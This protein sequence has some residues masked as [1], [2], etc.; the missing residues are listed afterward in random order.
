MRSSTATWPGP[1]RQG[2]ASNSHRPEHARACRSPARARRPP[3][4]LLAAARKDGD[5]PLLQDVARVLA[6]LLHAADKLHKCIS[7][8][9]R[10]E[11]EELE[12]SPAS[13]L[14]FHGLPWPS[15]TFHD[16]P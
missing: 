16:L 11:R 13:S 10:V 14:A 3:L 1:C 5:K 9:V 4:Q 2:A 12:P 7:A 15:M 8:M 6:E